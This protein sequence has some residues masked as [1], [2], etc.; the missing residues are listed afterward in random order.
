M[1]TIDDEYIASFEMAAQFNGWKDHEMAAALLCALDGPAR[2]ILTEFDDPRS[3]RYD[4]IKLGLKKRFNP[5]DITDI[6][7][8]APSQLQLQRGQNIRE[9]VQEVGRLTGKAYPGLEPRQRDRSHIKP[10]LNAIGDRD[11]VFNIKDKD[12]RDIEDACSM[13]E[14]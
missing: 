7:Q 1:S 14:R 9:L 3:A 11:A 12:P 8:Q 2:G 10:L 5:A 13:Y 4:S 6:H